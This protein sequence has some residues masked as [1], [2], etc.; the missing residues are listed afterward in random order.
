M[1]AADAFS[2]PQAVSRYAERTA[3][4]VPGLRDLHAMAGLLLAERAPADARVLVLGAGGGLELA[5][6][7]RA[8]PGWRFDGVDPSAEMLR[9][10]AATL[11]P[12]AP[13]ARLHQ[14]Y[15]DS[16]PDGPF[17]AAACLLTLHFLH[18]PER[19]ATLAEVRRR[20]KPGA[21]FV[22]AH[23]SFGADEA[24]RWLA[25]NAAFAVASGVPA[26]QAEGSI[27]AIRERLPVLAPERD[28]ALLREAGFAGV[29]LFYA[30]FT[31]KGWVA[32]AA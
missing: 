17:D 14:G 24:N 27:A 15:I 22:A 26:E 28:A 32:Y 12:L 29:E 25:R 9:L 31:F 21:A 8:W 16:A 30:A 6:F 19:R 2:D 18:E 3:R 4:I 7:A 10:A 23:H 20:L 1:N 5:A 11:G 13:R